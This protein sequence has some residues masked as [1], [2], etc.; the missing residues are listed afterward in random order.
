MKIAILGWGSLLWDEQPAF[1][2]HHSGWLDDGP[3]LNLEFSR[4]S[5]SRKGAL[6]LVIDEKDGAPCRVAYSISKR[7]DPN[8]AICDLRCREGTILRRIGYWFADPA[9]QTCDLVIPDGLSQWAK[10]K[11]LNVVIWTGL[12]SNFPESA[13]QDFSTKAAVGYLQ[14]LSSEAKAKATEYVRRA[15]DFVKTPLRTT[16]ESEPWFSNPL[17]E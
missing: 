17:G 3:T 4:V 1:D 12:E 2:D 8:D 10:S 13:K 16:L 7:A 6:T 9:G 5:A 14:G 15:P 11:S